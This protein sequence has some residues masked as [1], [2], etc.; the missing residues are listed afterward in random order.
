MAGWEKERRGP[1]PGR[2]SRPCCRS[3][4]G[5]AA[6]GLPE[7][8]VRS[9][10]SRPGFLSAPGLS[11]LVFSPPGLA[12][13]GLRPVP[14]VP[15]SRRGPRGAALREGLS[16]VGCP[17]PVPSP[18]GR[19]SCGEASREGRTFRVGLWSAAAPGGAFL[20]GVEALKA[21]GLVPGS[22]HPSGLRLRRTLGFFA[23]FFLRVVSPMFFAIPIWS[24]ISQT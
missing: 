23:T 21:G 1:A 4:P 12:V 9:G 17:G 15:G 3:A 5:L 6:P 16:G 2:L 10:A 14:S 13:V 8:R 24:V 11:A 18:R 22:T 20:V 7:S 19:V